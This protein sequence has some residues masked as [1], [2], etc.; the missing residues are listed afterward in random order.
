MMVIPDRESPEQFMGTSIRYDE[1]VVQ[2]KE[3][4]EPDS[5]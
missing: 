1:M 5:C 4:I 2:L 3:L